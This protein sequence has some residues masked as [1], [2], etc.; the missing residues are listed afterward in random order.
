MK[1]AVERAAKK[2]SLKIKTDTDFQKAVDTITKCM[3]CE[4][5]MPAFLNERMGV[6]PDQVFRCLQLTL[7][8][9]AA[10]KS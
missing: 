8:T 5:L 6:D 2:M 9:T 7:P 4:Q 1:R 10:V 3:T